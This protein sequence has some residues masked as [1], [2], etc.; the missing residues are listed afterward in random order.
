MMRISEAA[1]L[2][3]ARTANADMTFTSVF[4]DSRA[5]V[6]DGLFIALRGE[7]FDGHD[8]VAA[9]IAQGAA[10]AMVDE[11][12]AAAHADDKLPLLV[13]DDTRL[14]LGQLA[15]AWRTR[16][17]IPLI[18]ITGSNGKTTVKDMCAA[19]M[20]AHL[21]EDQVLAT[22]GNFNNDIGLP[23]TLLQLRERHRAAVI[24]MGMNHAGE[25]SYLT[26]I[27]RPTVA[28]INNAQ[29]AHLEGLSSLANVARAKGE[30]FE[31]LD[32]DGVAII[33]AD[34]PHAAIWRELAA[35]QRMQSFGLD[36]AADIGATVQCAQLRSHM[37]LHTPLG[38][39]GF[40]LQLAGRHNVLNA[41]A[42][43]AACLAAGAPLAAVV[44][45][46]AGYRGAKGRL[47]RKAGK[48]GAVLIDDTYNANP[49]SMRAAIDVLAQLPGKRLFVMGDMGEVGAA[50]GQFHDELG[51]YAKSQGID[52]L[53][54]LGSLAVAA[55]H[56][57]GQ[58]GTHFERIEDL[59]KAVRQ[60]LDANT[61]VLI[62]GS[63]FMRME[64]IVDALLAKDGEE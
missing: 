12:W 37:T 41:L 63:R 50:G 27:A 48:H 44:K 30:I 7:R 59:V 47:Q 49:D 9:A 43:A 22:G 17:A 6:K 36:R 14:G 46:L 25:I 31:G 24:E 60:E 40:E 29:R 18:A 4:S 8:F 54:C 5:I 20:A 10:A 19:I 62:K 13:V 2:L 34:D 16:F 1:A 56:N 57:F 32:R 33:N 51:G 35:G 42:A 28:L 58:H 45:G 11:K 55:A 21:G 15:A 53:Y 52:R 3:G 39:A 61:T 26:R 23:L 64:R 38:D